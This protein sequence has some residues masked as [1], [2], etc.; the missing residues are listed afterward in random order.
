MKL[1]SSDVL[2]NASFNDSKKHSFLIN[3][4]LIEALQ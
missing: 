1:K 3:H 4:T 2:K